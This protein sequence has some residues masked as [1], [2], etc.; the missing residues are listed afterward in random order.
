MIGWPIRA[1][2][3]SGCFDRIIVSTDN[4]EIAEIASNQGAEIPFMRPAELADDYT[5]TT[6]VMRHAVDWLDEHS[7][8]ASLACC[9]YPTAPFVTADVLKRGLDRIEQ[10]DVA[11]AF[12]VTTFAFPIQ[13]AIRITEAGRIEMFQPEHMATRSQDLED[14]YHDA[15][16]FYWGLPDAWREEKPLFCQES[17][18]IQL[19]RHLVHDIDTRE[20]WQRAELIFRAL[21][22][23]E[24][25]A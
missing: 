5:G 18:A 21:G 8:S 4:T 22:F 10:R 23:H 16:Q 3:R 6:S 25:D 24:N 12:S 11:Y 19:P 13:R 1:A 20:D 9:L 15:G 2:I 17:A 7:K 14:A